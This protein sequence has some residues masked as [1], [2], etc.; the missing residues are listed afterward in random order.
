MHHL[1][2]PISYCNVLSVAPFRRVA[3]YLVTEQPLVVPDA[4]DGWRAHFAFFSRS[5][6]TDA[7]VQEAIQHEAILVDLDLLGQVFDG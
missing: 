4:G 1:E 7:A 3:V 5:G 2:P 6:F